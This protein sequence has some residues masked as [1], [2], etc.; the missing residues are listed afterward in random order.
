MKALKALFILSMLGLAACAPEGYVDPRLAPAVSEVEKIFNSHGISIS[1]RVSFLVDDNRSKTGATGAGGGVVQAVCIIT[2][3][4][5]NP[6]YNI[7]EIFVNPDL[8]V[9]GYISN[10]LLLFLVHELGHCQFR[11]KHIGAGFD[12]HNGYTQGWSVDD[13]RFHIMNSY[14]EDIQETN[15]YYDKIFALAK[16]SKMYTFVQSISSLYEK[17]E[18]EYSCEGHDH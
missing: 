15:S 5:E 3:D 8:V 13:E 6:L 14:I 2:R 7:K 16:T 1:D 4:I 18:V 9:E 11:M 17:E 12:K 10:T